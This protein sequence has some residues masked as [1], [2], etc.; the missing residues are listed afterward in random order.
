MTT[1]PTLSV[2]GTTVRVAIGIAAMAAAG[3]PAFAAQRLDPDA[4]AAIALERHPL[5][6]AAAR[7]SDAAQADKKLARSGWL[8][9]LDFTED[10]VR[11]TNPV[12]V[13]ASKLGQESFG[14][15]DAIQSLNTPDPYTNAGTRVGLQQ[16]IWDG[17][18]TTA[19]GHA[20]KAG[21]AAADAVLVRTRDEIAF[22][23]KRAFWDAVLADEMAAAARDAE[24][25]A[26]ANAELAKQMVEEGIAVPSDRMQAD[27][28]VGEMRAMRVRTEQ[29]VLVARAALRRALGAPDGEEFTLDPPSVDPEAAAAADADL[30]VTVADAL[31]TRADLAAFDARIG[32]AQA[33]EDLALSTL[34]PKIGV[35]AQYEWNGTTPFGNDEQLDRQ[36]FAHPALRRRRSARRERA[37]ADRERLEALQRR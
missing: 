10:Y 4:A 26:V 31:S 24:K 9:R 21:I 34:L 8:P 14:P 2:F 37:R 32:Q 20:A 25:A 29:G 30:G 12:F 6:R 22:G 15:Q 28:R 11:S 23:A 19:A 1:T 13:F 35:G 7:E 27:V 18:R 33:G 3:L 17:G 5:L 16:N 36:A